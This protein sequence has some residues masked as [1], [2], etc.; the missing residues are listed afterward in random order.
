[1]KTYS[2]II[3]LICALLSSY[4]GIKN[5]LSP[6]YQE[7][8][9][10]N[11]IVGPGWLFFLCCSIILFPETISKTKTFRFNIS[12]IFSVLILM[13]LILLATSSMIGTDG[14]W[15]KTARDFFYL[16]YFYLISIYFLRYFIGTGEHVSR[17]I[18][19]FKGYISTF[20][21]LTFITFMAG[22]FDGEGRFMGAQLTSSVFGNYVPIICFFFLISVRSMWLSL[23][24]I[25]ISMAMIY[26]SG[27]RTAFII[28]II[29]VCYFYIQYRKGAR[30]K[31]SLIFL[32]LISVFFYAILGNS[33]SEESA[34]LLTTEEAEMGSVGTRIYW[35]EL[36]FNK[37]VKD[38]WYGG[39]GG[40]AA[41]AE[42][43]YLTHA[44]FLRFWFDYGFIFAIGVFLWC[45]YLFFFKGFRFQW[46]K[47][48]DLL[49]FFS[50]LINLTFHNLFQIPTLLFVTAL[51][52]V[53]I[54]KRKVIMSFDITYRTKG[55]L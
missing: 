12:A 13:G 44:D 19:F 46:D 39:Y 2:V 3:G 14:V 41:E 52:G 20:F 4:D 43:G 18:D 8:G 6:S 29:L 47:I 53:V 21:I 33:G 37:I 34:R 10:N 28:F 54:S 5:L 45:M 30:K 40:G 55:K 38:G 7:V 42:I 35:Y 24:V 36:L 50:V 48:F 15:S 22:K 31:S 25:I 49:T 51:L 9:S 17:L 32:L 26:L 16:F 23:S 1:M 27:T 11:M